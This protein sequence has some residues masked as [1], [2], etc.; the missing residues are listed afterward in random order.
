MQAAITRKPINFMSR[1]G[2]ALAIS[3]VLIVVSILA[4]HFRGLNFGIDFS[5]GYLIEVGYSQ[6]VDLSQ[7]RD[8]LKS[9]QFE[10]VS[11]QHF[12]SARDVLIRL[13]ITG[14]L[15]DVTVGDQVLKALSVNAEQTSSDAPSMRRVEFVGPQIGDELRERGGLAVLYALFCIVLYIWLRYEKKF[16]LGAVLALVHDVL[17]IVGLFAITQ[18]TFDLSVLAA[19]LAIIGYSLND[20]IVVF[21]RIRE[22]FRTQLDIEPIGVIN[23]S[24]NQ[25]LS[26][27]I[28]TSFTT[29]LVLVSL[30]LFGGEVINA[31]A[32][33]LI[34]GVLVGTY[35]SIFVAGTA[36]LKLGVSHKDLMSVTPEG[37]SLDAL[38]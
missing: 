13:P 22:N 28:T 14:S 25:V 29:L 11:V 33:A 35:S 20:T 7:V 10:E 30:Y 37:E 4:I 23:N 9:A 16:A 6:T 2:V 38:P 17:L 1:N 34:A 26:R 32:V 12:G 27:T 19:I 3:G 21:D 31:F 5:G 24:L 36:I 8:A 18:M 15:T